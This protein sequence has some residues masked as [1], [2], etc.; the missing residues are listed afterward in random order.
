[1]CLFI[2]RIRRKS[3]V[4]RNDEKIR[5]EI[6]KNLEEGIKSFYWEESLSRAMDSESS[7]KKIAKN[8]SLEIKN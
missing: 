6:I 1:M 5:K 3:V 8:I 2:R 4:K 7:P